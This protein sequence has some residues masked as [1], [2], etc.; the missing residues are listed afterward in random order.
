MARRKLPP[1]TKAKALELIKTGADTLKI[2]LDCGVSPSTIDKWKKEASGDGTTV[3][4][5]A[6]DTTNQS[7]PN[8]A[9]TA[10]TSSGPGADLGDLLRKHPGTGFSAPPPQ[11]IAPPPVPAPKPMD[12][13]ALI[14]LVIVIKTMVVQTASDAWKIE[15]SEEERARLCEFSDSEKKALRILAPAAADYSASMERYAKPIMACLFG[16][17]A[18]FSTISSLKYLKSKRP[19]KA[20]NVMKKGPKK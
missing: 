12:P 13:E 16:G 5:A 9:P 18:A 2:A 8:P 17:V 11:P 19:P 7:L 6:P 1:G 15:L 3:S 10:A 14:G 4:I 20:Q